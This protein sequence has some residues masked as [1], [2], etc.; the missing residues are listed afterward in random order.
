MLIILVIS[1]Y[2]EQTGISRSKHFPCKALFTL[3]TN[4]NTIRFQYQQ[5]GK[6][7]S[8]EQQMPFINPVSRATVNTFLSGLG[9]VVLLWGIG[10]H[11]RVAPLGEI[12]RHWHSIAD[13]VVS[14][15]MW[16]TPW[17][18]ADKFQRWVLAKVQPPPLPVRWGIICLWVTL[19]ERNVGFR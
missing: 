13:V 6:V 4:I 15:I 3:E 18:G 1:P 2:L 8:Q 12:I 19:S 14:S 16:D 5:R 17:L 9:R 10:W 7:G 11:F